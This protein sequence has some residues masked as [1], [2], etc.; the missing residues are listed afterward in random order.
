MIKN[1]LCALHVDE[2][3]LCF[4]EDSGDGIFSCNEMDILIIDLN[5]IDLDDTNYDEDDPDETTIHIRLLT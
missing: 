5:N 3:I 2:N 1:L 4:N